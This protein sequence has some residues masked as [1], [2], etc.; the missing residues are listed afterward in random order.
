[1][2][3]VRKSNRAQNLAQPNPELF[4]APTTSQQPQQKQQLYEKVSNCNTMTR[5]IL[6]TGSILWT[7]ITFWLAIWAISYASKLKSNNYDPSAVNQVSTTLYLILYILYIFLSVAIIIVVLIIIFRSYKTKDGE[8][9]NASPLFRITF[10]IYGVVMLFGVIY[11]ILV[12]SVLLPVANSVKDTTP[13]LLSEGFANF[14][15]VGGIVL[16]SLNVVLLIASTIVVFVKTGTVKYDAEKKTL[17]M[18]K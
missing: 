15:Y 11:A 5:S 14:F 13:I 17:L 9:C 3:N 18:K 16:L 1:M 7:I 10:L 6:L 2:A 8:T 4:N 12:L